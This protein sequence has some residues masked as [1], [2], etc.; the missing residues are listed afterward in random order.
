MS[1]LID[2]MFGQKIRGVRVIPLVVKIVVIFTVLLLVSNFVTNYIN[3]ML[4]RGQL[5]KLANQLLVK[6]LTELSIFSSNQYQIYSFNNDLAGAIKSIE[7]SA[8]KGLQRNMS[9]ALGVK[10]DGDIFFQAS[11]QVH[12]TRFTDQAALDRMNAV[13]GGKAPEG[14]LLFKLNGNQYIGVFKYSEQWGVFIIRAEELNEFYQE[15]WNI[16]RTTSIIIVIITLICA[17]LG[18]FLIR[19]MLRYVRVITQ[20][21]MNM[22]KKQTM[23]IIDLKGAPNDD[24]TFLGVALNS[25]TST[26]D[27]MMDIFRKFVTTDLVQKAYREREIRLEGAQRDL[28][29]L[30]TDIRGFTYM[31]EALGNDIIKL[32]NLHYDRAIHHIQ[33]N[34]GIVGSIIG[35]ALLAVFGTLEGY[36]SNKSYMAVRSAYQVQD[37][38]AALREDMA[39]RREEIAKRHGALSTMD[40]QVYRAVLLE[41]GVGID[42]GE[43]FYGTIGSY[44]RM[45]NTVIGD[46]VNSSSRLEGLTRFYKVP[47]IVSEYVKH[48]VERDYDDYVFME[49]DRVQVKGKTEGKKIFWPIPKKSMDEDLERDVDAF[50]AGLALY[51]EGQWPAAYKAFA[52]CALPVADIFRDRTKNNTSPKGWDGVWAMTM[53]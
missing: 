34:G 16:F 20:G 19:Y 32:L 26:I 24:V 25:T 17:V 27:N 2:R 48:E 33:E 12:V 47:V 11:K 49:I 28:T 18:V 51:Y 3:L 1:A 9:V 43:V 23:D 35:D 38:A 21:I 41:V 8:A 15:S 14:S 5:L 13:K 39:K 52:K 30:F 22:Q 7:A 42:G 45:T 37:V 44:E 6:D 29:V 10:P 40:E 36:G 50:S 46:N 53:K 4:N 31:T